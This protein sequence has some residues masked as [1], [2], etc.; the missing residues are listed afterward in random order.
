MSPLT[1]CIS[2]C[3]N[4]FSSGLSQVIE[5]NRWIYNLDD[6]TWSEAN[7]YCK[8]HYNTSLATITSD[9]EAKDLLEFIQNVSY[10]SG[11]WIG[12]NDKETEGLWAWAS[13]H[14]WYIPSLDIYN[15]TALPSICSPTTLCVNI[16]YIHHHLSQ[17][18]MVLRLSA[19]LERRRTE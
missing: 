3:W 18:T 10:N 9:E 4:L 8:S 15:T 2:I 13:G 17:F 11:P 1:F 12:L 14:S 7:S 6:A 16:T 19:V 5:S